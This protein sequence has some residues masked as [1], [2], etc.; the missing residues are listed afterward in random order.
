MR[1]L[2][3]HFR[4]GRT[5]QGLPLGADAS[6]PPGQIAWRPIILAAVAAAAA[7]IAYEAIKLF[8]T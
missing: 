8:T 1:R 3:G 7:I 4:V 5:R 6:R 2:F